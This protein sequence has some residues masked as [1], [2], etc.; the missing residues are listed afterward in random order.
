MEDEMKRIPELEQSETGEIFL[1]E[2]LP[3]TDRVPSALKAV[4]AMQE[5]ALR[6]LKDRTKADIAFETED[7]H[8][9]LVEVKN[10]VGRGTGTSRAKARRPPRGKR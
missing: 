4:W 2:A 8:L 1:G 3:R 6:R 9:I 10:L 5:P 7:G